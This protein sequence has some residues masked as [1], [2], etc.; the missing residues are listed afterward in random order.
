MVWAGVRC[1]GTPPRCHQALLLCSYSVLCLVAVSCRA[2]LVATVWAGVRCPATPLRC[3]QDGR[4]RL[5]QSQTWE[6][7]RCAS[8]QFECVSHNS[9][10]GAARRIKNSMQLVQQQMLAQQVHPRLSSVFVEIC[11]EA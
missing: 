10:E 6:E 1:L 5:S 11:A 9:F 4:R 2:S 7:L 8:C 3:H